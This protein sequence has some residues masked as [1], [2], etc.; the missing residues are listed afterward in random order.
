MSEEKSTRD[1]SVVEELQRLQKEC[2]ESYEEY[3]EA[4]KKHDEKLDTLKGLWWKV[5]CSDDPNIGPYTDSD[6]KQIHVKINLQNK[7]FIE[8]RDK[9]IS[10]LGDLASYFMDEQL[11]L[12]PLYNYTLL[13]TYYSFKG[14]IPKL[15]AGI[16]GLYSNY[17]YH[18]INYKCCNWCEIRAMHRSWRGIDNSSNT[19]HVYFV[20]Y[21]SDAR[22]YSLF[23]SNEYK[24]I[25]TSVTRYSSQRRIT[26][27][28]VIHLYYKPILADD[29]LI[30]LIN[31]N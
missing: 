2:S 27:H 7:D 5:R 29:T 15:D 28:C 12:C 9:I 8:L 13:A 26:I 25:S 16:V 14:Y 20:Y 21:N 17:K 4:K 24:P 31:N 3:F 30:Q 19:W 6:K 11:N 10:E 22:L 18:I 23:P 1:I